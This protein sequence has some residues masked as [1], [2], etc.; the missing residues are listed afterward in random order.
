MLP[1]TSPT[2]MNCS[3]GEPPWFLLDA[4]SPTRRH[5]AEAG[6]CC[7]RSDSSEVV[8]S[9]HPGVAFQP[10]WAG[11]SLDLASRGAHVEHADEAGE[12]EQREQSRRHDE[13]DGASRR[14]E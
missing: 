12:L 14:C 2:T 6:R 5:D 8:P 4:R 11:E 13:G 3:T 10:R 7:S 1:N 9:A